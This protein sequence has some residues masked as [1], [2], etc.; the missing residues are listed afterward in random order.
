MTIKFYNGDVYNIGQTINGINKFI[1]IEG[2]WH[3][4]SEEIMR[5]YE[6]AQADLTKLIYD[7]KINGWD[8]VKFLGN[9]F[10]Y[11]VK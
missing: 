10:S 11:I 8:E 5:E 3:Y 6:Y 9:I 2:K 4:Y 1:F 7:D